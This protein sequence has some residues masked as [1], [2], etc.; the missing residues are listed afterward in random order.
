MRILDESLAERRRKKV[1]SALVSTYISTGEPVASSRVLSRS[2]LDLSP[3]TVRAVIAQLDSLGL[4]IQPHTSAGR[5]PTQKG[6]RA[7]VESLDFDDAPPR[8]FWAKV[9]R[10]YDLFE[11]EETNVSGFLERF[12]ALV[13]E[14]SGEAGIILSP[15]FV[16]DVIREIKLVEVGPGRVLAVVISNLG[17]VTSTTIHVGR[18]LGYFNLKRIEEYLNGKLTGARTVS[19]FSESYFDETEA[20]TGERLYNEVVLKY[21]VSGGSSGKR[22]LYLEGFSKIFEKK[23]MHDPEAAFSAVK[24]FEEKSR[25]IHVLESCQR[26]DSVSVLIG[27]E[28]QPLRGASVGLGL[29]CSP[30]KVNA[31]S[32]GVLGVIGSMRMRYAKIIPLVEHAALFLSRKLTE[33]YGRARIGFDLRRP[34]TMTAA[35]NR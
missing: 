2:R 35:P 27:D 19:P 31:V 29:V 4:T 15:G 17:V 7:F 20:A 13:S 25:L 12:C 9:Q 22:Q 33:T 1:L 28:L 30:Y 21:L 10:E 18:K 14:S 6:L 32:A 23:E 8:D 5:I 26:K 34:F 24:F 16:N 11:A 3:A